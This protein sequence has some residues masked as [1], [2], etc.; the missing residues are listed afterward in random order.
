[1]NKIQFYIYISVIGGD[2]DISKAITT[3]FFIQIVP[4]EQ[5]FDFHIKENPYFKD[6]ENESQGLYIN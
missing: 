3:L 6:I 2:I 4:F 1:M 5:V